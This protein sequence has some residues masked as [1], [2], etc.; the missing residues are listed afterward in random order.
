MS[1]SVCEQVR[2]TNAVFRATLVDTISEKI[3]LPSVR[4]ENPARKSKDLVRAH[5]PERTNA[6]PN[7]SSRTAGAVLPSRRGNSRV[8]AFLS[9]QPGIS[10]SPDRSEGHDQVRRSSAAEGGERQEMKPARDRTRAAAIA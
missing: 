10:A 6:R 7:R 2:S 5:A 9:D 1:G 8:S 3:Q 4:S